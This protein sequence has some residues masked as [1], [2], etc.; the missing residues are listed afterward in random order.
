MVQSGGVSGGELANFIL[1][2][3]D[4]DCPGKDL[5]IA[6]YHGN[7][8]ELR[9]L[10]EK[11]GDFRR[12]IDSR[13]RPFGATPLRLAATGARSFALLTKAPKKSNK[14]TF[15][16]SNMAVLNSNRVLCPFVC[17]ATFLASLFYEE[18]FLFMNL[19][20]SSQLRP[21]MKFC[22]SICKMFVSC[23]RICWNCENF[24]RVRS[25]Y[26]PRGCQSSDSSFRRPG[27][28][29]LGLRKVW[30]ITKIASQEFVMKQKHV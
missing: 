26:W 18:R 22:R 23:S 28:P 2:V 11:N 17:T 6:A 30:K 14:A 20:I 7:V 16:A 13:I 1:D 29:A 10:L 24:G 27:Y 3:S 8:E 21:E 12:E 19:L 5:H 9:K 25:R 4:E 15:P